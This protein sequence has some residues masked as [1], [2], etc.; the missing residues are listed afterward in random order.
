[1]AYMPVMQDGE[2]RKAGNTIYAV[3]VEQIAGDARRAFGEAERLNHH[4]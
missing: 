1:M 4:A 3:F 2:L